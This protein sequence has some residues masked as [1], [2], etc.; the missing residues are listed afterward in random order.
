VSIFSGVDYVNNSGS[1]NISPPLRLDQLQLHDNTLDTSALSNGTV[2]KKNTL[3]L[4]GDGE[5]SIENG[6]GLDAVA[7][8]IRGDSAVLTVYMKANSSYIMRNISNG[9]YRLIFAQGLDWNATT[10][11]FRRNQQ[12]SSFDEVLDFTVTEDE[13]YYYFTEFNVTL[14]DV[15]GG[16]AK[17][18]DITASQF[19]KY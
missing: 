16:T 11:K 10:Q 17:T 15:A 7:K 18:H 4:Q 6:T 2:L 3:Y 14:H 5:L 12:Y 19:D 1:K 8:L 13:Q 9:T